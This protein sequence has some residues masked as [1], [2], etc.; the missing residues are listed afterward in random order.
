MTRSVAEAARDAVSGKDET[1]WQVCC[2]ISAELPK[3]KSQQKRLQ[4]HIEDIISE[5]SAAE[6]K[7][8]DIFP[9]AEK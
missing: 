9:E 4:T 2:S 3:S 6:L 8:Y 1:L 5:F 7:L